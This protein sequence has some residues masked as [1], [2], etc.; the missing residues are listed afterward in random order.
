LRTSF[1]KTSISS[2][3]CLVFKSKLKRALK[4]R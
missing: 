3:F 2:I 1:V 4:F